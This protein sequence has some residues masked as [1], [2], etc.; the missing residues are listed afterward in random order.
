MSFRTA[1]PP[2]GHPA[3]RIWSYAQAM[4]A[5]RIPDATQSESA[6]ARLAAAMG[7]PAP[8]PLTPEEKAEFERRQAE[9]DALPRVYGPS[10]PAAA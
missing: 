1:T 3:D 4:D 9:A 8:E 10:K 6:A 7:R 5:R 2:A